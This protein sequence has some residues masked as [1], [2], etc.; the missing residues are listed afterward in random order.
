MHSSRGQDMKK[1]SVLYLSSTGLSVAGLNVVNASSLN[2]HDDRQWDLLF[3]VKITNLLKL[4][5]P[6]E[7]S[8]SPKL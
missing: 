5:K 6:L 7:Q 1:T 2:E 3:M 4:L 8:H